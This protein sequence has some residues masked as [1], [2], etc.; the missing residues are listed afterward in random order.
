ME[1]SLVYGAECYEKQPVV[2]PLDSFSA[3]H[4]TRRFITEFTRALGNALYYSVQIPSPSR[5]L[6]KVCLW[7]SM[8]VKLGL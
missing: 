6:P 3:F 2:K 8:G 4:G 7:F 1:F 5:L